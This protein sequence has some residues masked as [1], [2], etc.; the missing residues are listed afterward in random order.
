MHSTI[1]KDK[2]NYKIESIQRERRYSRFCHLL[3]VIVTDRKLCSSGLKYILEYFLEV[4][5][6]K[7]QVGI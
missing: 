1:F 3:I 2:L 5:Q 6:K 7:E 4:V